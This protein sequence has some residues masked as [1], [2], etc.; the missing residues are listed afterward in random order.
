[1]MG[2]L[3]GGGFMGLTSMMSFVGEMM[4]TMF[5]SMLEAMQ[6]FFDQMMA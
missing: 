3:L 6:Q 4:M 5:G 2:G 1:M